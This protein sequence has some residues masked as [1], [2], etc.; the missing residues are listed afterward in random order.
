[1]KVSSENGAYN[2]LDFTHSAPLTVNIYTT[3][4][5]S[6]MVIPKFKRLL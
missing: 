2:T 5:E 6:E 3:L 1:V 4:L